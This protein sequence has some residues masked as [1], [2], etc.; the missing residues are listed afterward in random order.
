M[1]VVPSVIHVT[2]THN[3]QASLNLSVM[4][5]HILNRTQVPAREYNFIAYL[6]ALVFELRPAQAASQLGQKALPSDSPTVDM[7][8]TH[9]RLSI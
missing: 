8:L 5:C 4:A 3:T 7:S 2:G 6:Y 1:V 9:S